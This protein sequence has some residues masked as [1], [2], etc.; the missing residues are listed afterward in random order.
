MTGGGLP[1]L[2][3]TCHPLTCWAQLLWQ[4]EWLEPRREPA[5]QALPS[6][7]FRLMVPL[8]GAPRGAGFGVPPALGGELQGLGCHPTDSRGRLVSL[9]GNSDSFE[10]SCPL[11]SASLG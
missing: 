3:G 7:T 1:I 5:Q 8:S 10:S 6:G 9:C 11:K 2:K 4:G